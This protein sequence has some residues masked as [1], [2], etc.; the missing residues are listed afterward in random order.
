VR[1]FF[2]TGLLR[3]G[4]Y[5]VST[6]VNV[7]VGESFEG[8]SVRVGLIQHDMYGELLW[9]IVKYAEQTYQQAECVLGIRTEIGRHLPVD[10]FDHRTLQYIHDWIA[11]QFRFDYCKNADLFEFARHSDKNETERVQVCWREFLRAETQRL[12]GKYPSLAHNILI[13]VLFPNPKTEG[14]EAEEQLCALI[15]EAY[16]EFPRLA[17]EHEQLS[18]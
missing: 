17:F 1:V 13:A 8:D 10:S 15:R 9:I 2:R 12:L 4:V 14:M 6:E 16:P 18:C 7:I 11:A 5:G 3:S